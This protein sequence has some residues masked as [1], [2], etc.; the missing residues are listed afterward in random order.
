MN[1]KTSSSAIT[2]QAQCMIAG[3]ESTETQKIHRKEKKDYHQ[4]TERED[5]QILTKKEEEILMLKALYIKHS[6][7]YKESFYK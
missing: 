2:E 1:Y 5:Q 6:K 3:T 4:I 7:Y